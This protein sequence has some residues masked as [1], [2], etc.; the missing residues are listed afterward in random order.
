MLGTVLKLEDTITDVLSQL[1][2]GRVDT[3]ARM[4]WHVKSLLG[5]LSSHITVLVQVLVTLLSFILAFN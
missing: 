1:I 5:T 4:L 2:I 3:Y